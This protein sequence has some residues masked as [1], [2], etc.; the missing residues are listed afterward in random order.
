MLDGLPVPP[1]IAGIVALV[2]ALATLWGTVV[3]GRKKVNDDLDEIR[4]KQNTLLTEYANLLEKRMT[5]ERDHYEKLLA[6]ERRDCDERIVRLERRIK[7]LEGK[8]R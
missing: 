2:G 4:G 3:S 1:I 8:R 5:G 7:T 6:A